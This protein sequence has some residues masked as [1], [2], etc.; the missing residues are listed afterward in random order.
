[1]K[2]C[3]RLFLAVVLAAGLTMGLFANGLNLNG[4]GAKSDAMG[5]AFVGLAN[6]FSAAYWNPAGLAQIAKASFSLYGAD[7]LP[8]GTYVFSGAGV[9]A[10]S[11]PKHYLIPGLG[12][13]QPLG[14][15]FV[16]GVYVYAPSGAGSTYDGADLANLTKFTPYDW[17]S[18][19][20]IFT[21]SPAIAY[22]ISDKVLIGATV[23]INYGMLKMAQP[24]QPAPGLFTQYSEDLKGWAVNGTLGLLVKPVKQ[25]SFGVTYKLPFTAK[26]KGDVT[27]PAAAGFGLPTTD[28]G[29]RTAKWPMWLAGGIA[30]KPTDKLTITADVQY[31]NWK[32]LDSIP[33][34]FT[35]P[36]WQA[37][38]APE[39]AYNLAWKDTFQY[40]I[41]AEYW[42]SNSFAL[43]AGYYIDENPGPIESQ[44]ILLPEFKYNWFTA[45]FGYK[46]DKF[47]IDAAIQYGVGGDITVPLSSYIPGQNM[48]GVH[49]MSMWVPSLNFT[50]KF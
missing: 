1:M 25:F 4:T 3:M 11:T 8:T 48:P 36:G 18:K 23:D 17:N 39:A 9:D 20:G 31:T 19:L 35:N 10:K 37:A 6:D 47:V 26:L 41:G 2:T 5:G 50:Y 15:K 7:I 28:T 42:I 14:K 29:T 43:R 22:K 38:L 32:E 49:G 46:S 16:V 24:I 30:V 13:F 27:I 44:N 45:G 21:I 34:S 33:V 40:R 12:Y